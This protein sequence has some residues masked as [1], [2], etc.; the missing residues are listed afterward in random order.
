MNPS[1]QSLKL[2]FSIIQQYLFS[3][4]VR[5]VLVKLHPLLFLLAG[6]QHGEE[7]CSADPAGTKQGAVVRE[8]Q[9]VHE[10]S[11]PSGKSCRRLN[12]LTVPD[13][14]GNLGKGTKECW[15]WD[16]PIGKTVNLAPDT[17]ETQG[18]LHN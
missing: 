14:S 18:C 11:F 8:S 9:T 2:T 1:K 5:A 3:W 4:Q 15:H 10:V 6:I 13:L 7:Q 17:Q 12:E 16:G